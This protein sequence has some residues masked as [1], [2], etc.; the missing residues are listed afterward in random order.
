SAGYVFHTNLSP[1]II[2]GIGAAGNLFQ[3]RAG[4]VFGKSR[5][6]FKLVRIKLGCHVAAAAPAFV[7]YAPKGDLVRRRMS[8]LL[9]H[10]RHRAGTVGVNV[11]Y[12]LRHL[13]HSSATHVGSYVRLAAKQ[14]AKLQK[15]V[16]AKTI[17][18]GYSAPIGVYHSW[19]LRGGAYTVAPMVFI[20]KTAAGPAQVG[21]FYLFKRGNHIQA[22]T[23]LFGNRQR[24]IHP[25]TAV[26]AMSQMLG[27]LSVNMFADRKFRVVANRQA[28]CIL[29][30]C[31][32]A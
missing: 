29:G 30:K 15:L 11:F 2:L 31:S 3:W 20:R 21:Y 1:V 18:L 8:V 32:E 19:P 25:K 5:I 6:P 13:F 26:N 16:G 22:N 24:F 7:A 28:C 9:T 14:T 17:I 23:V 4:I 12:P 27:E 10:L